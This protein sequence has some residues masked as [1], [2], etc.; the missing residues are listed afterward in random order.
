MR[1]SNDKRSLNISN[2]IKSLKGFKNWD[3][4][5][6]VMGDDINLSRTFSDHL[7]VKDDCVKIELSTTDVIAQNGRQF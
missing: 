7:I 3:K 6:Y 2:R 4:I 1:E 5:F